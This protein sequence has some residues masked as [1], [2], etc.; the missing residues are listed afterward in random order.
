[1]SLRISRDS[2]IFLSS[3]GNSPNYWDA[4]GLDIFNNNLGNVVISSPQVRIGINAGASNQLASTIAIGV[5]AGESNQG[6]NGIAIGNQAGIVNQLQS[7]VAIGRRAGYQNQ[8]TQS[9]A[10]GLSA[11][12]TNQ[13][14]DSIAI[15]SLAGT[16]DQS[17]NCVAIGLGAGQST[18]GFQAIGIGNRA[19]HQFQQS[20]AIAIGSFAGRF[21]QGTS[22]IAIGNTAGNNLQ[23]AYSV[24]IGSF[25]GGST[26][27]SSAIVIDASA[28]VIGQAISATQQGLYIRPIRDVDDA[29][30]QCLTYNPSTRE[31]NRNT[32]AT[33]T[34]VID[35]P[36]HEDKYLI[37]GCLEGPESGVYYRGKGEILN[38]DSVDIHLPD[39]TKYFN[40]FTIQ[41]TP[42]NSTN[43][44]GVSKV[45]NGKFK[46]FGKN[47]EFF[48]LAHGT[49]NS[50]QVEIN[51][52][53]TIVKGDG[54]YKY[55]F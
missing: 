45:E 36:L 19:G 12:A 5:Q 7:S 46:V 8:S 27:T 13:L 41:V 21:S 3:Q 38:G 43:T 48:W 22:S 28:T 33:K 26:I 30:Q 23:G 42:I 10:I 9:I 35:H 11:G 32:N 25:A 40:N 2:R 37:H 47:G 4:S 14:Q 55:V 17:Q 44:Y 52:S 1:M 20:G 31:V 34:F 39:Y 49:R 51:K 29:T 15:G 53:E 24:A 54:P 6:T 16:Q 50:I 18:Q